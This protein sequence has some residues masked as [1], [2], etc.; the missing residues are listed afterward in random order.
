MVAIGSASSPTRQKKMKIAPHHLNVADRIVRHC[1][2]IFLENKR[3]Q[4][5][6]STSATVMQLFDEHDLCGVFIIGHAFADG[7]GNQVISIERIGISVSCYIENRA[8]PVFDS[9]DTKEEFSSAVFI[10]AGVRTCHRKDNDYEGGQVAKAAQDTA[11]SAHSDRYH[12]T[13]RQICQINTAVSSP[14]GKPP[15]QSKCQGADKRQTRARDQVTEQREYDNIKERGIYAIAQKRVVKKQGIGKS[16][17]A[18]RSDYLSHRKR[19]TSQHT[20][21]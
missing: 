9:R 15:K 20:H 12:E 13:D 14:C 10:E 6:W 2:Q 19:Q 4:L 7:L 3:L 5:S 21:H 17:E 8:K 16:I 11:R 18:Y 1:R